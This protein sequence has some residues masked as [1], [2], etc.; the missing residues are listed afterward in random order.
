MAVFY[1]IA[2]VFL[3]FCAEKI[4]P[5]E[6][7][8]FV[9]PFVKQLSAVNYSAVPGKVV[10]SEVRTT[11]NSRGRK[12]YS[13]DLTYRYSALGRDFEGHQFRYFDETR[14]AVNPNLVDEPAKAYPKGATVTVFTIPRIPRMPY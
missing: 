12:R 6:Y 2:L 13:F 4:L 3:S 14:F 10:E 11:I 5:S 9:V 7:H 1:L 8:R